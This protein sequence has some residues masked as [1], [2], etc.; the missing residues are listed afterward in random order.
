MMLRNPRL[1]Q[2]LEAHQQAAGSSQMPFGI[3]RNA[4]LE[5]P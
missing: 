1:D 5:G 2:L 3:L 4:T